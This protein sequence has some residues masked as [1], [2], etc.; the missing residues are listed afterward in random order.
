LWWV[1]YKERNLLLTA[2][3][4]ARRAS[5]PYGPDEE[6][7]YLKVKRSMAGIKHVINERKDIDMKLNPPE[8]GHNKTPG[9]RTRIFP[10]PE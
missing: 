7:R 4:R 6:S 8:E 3:E 9:R 5:R 1:L 10:K 2:R